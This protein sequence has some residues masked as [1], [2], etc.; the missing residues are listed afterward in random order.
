MY[1]RVIDACYELAILE[2]LITKQTARLQRSHAETWS[3]CF[4]LKTETLR[5]YVICKSPS[6]DPMKQQAYRLSCYKMKLE[7]L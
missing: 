7:A 2:E 1:N 4:L 5:C 3:I 6:H